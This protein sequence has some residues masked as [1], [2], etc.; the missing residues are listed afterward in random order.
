VID[1]SAALPSKYPTMDGSV[2]YSVMKQLL[3]LV[4]TIAPVNPAEFDGNHHMNLQ[5][6][7]E[8]EVFLRGLKGRGLF[9]NAKEARYELPGQKPLDPEGYASPQWLGSRAGNRRP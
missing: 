1:D 6:F 2:K 4:R 3:L 7:K 5:R 9:W 8:I